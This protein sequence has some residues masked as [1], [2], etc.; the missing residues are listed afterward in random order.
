LLL[1]VHASLKM[2]MDRQFMRRYTPPPPPLWTLCT[3][4][5]ED[6]MLSSYFLSYEQQLRIAQLFLYTQSAKTLMIILD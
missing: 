3:L 1:L 5:V 6:V 2:Q 4:H